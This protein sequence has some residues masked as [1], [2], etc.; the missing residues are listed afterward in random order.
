RSIWI[1][2]DISPIQRAAAALSTEA[3]LFDVRPAMTFFDAP[4]DRPRWLGDR[5]FWGKNPTFGAALSFYLGHAAK[6]VR[7]SV[8][9]NQNVE[10]ADLDGELTAGAR[11]PGI[12]RVY[13]DLR[14]QALPFR[15]IPGEQR[16]GPTTYFADPLPGPFVLAGDYRVTL[17][18]DGK[19]VGSKTVQVTN[20][21]LVTISDEDRRA[22]HDTALALH[23]L[24]QSADEAAEAVASLSDELRAME[25][26][27]APDRL[28]ESSLAGTLDNVRKKLAD[29]R[30]RLGVSGQGEG[31]EGSGAGGGSARA[32][33]NIR[34]RITST[35][36]QIAG[37]M[38]APTADQ[39]AEARAV[40]PELSDAITELN[41]LIATDFPALVKALA[42][43]N[44]WQ[45]VKPVR[46]IT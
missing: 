9:D 37:A 10:I 34:A 8:R 32:R 14:H 21:R 25:R 45:T 1:L 12:N 41:T 23:L 30:V 29:L 43:N 13:W 18:V 17:S 39:A 28:R 24:Q 44:A 33:R 4:E 40:R 26:L 27:A 6:E 2:D 16:P 5:P 22:W 46:P 31:G 19:E 15:K 11:Q 20:D 3:T 7:L 36:T 42:G 38:S 35:K